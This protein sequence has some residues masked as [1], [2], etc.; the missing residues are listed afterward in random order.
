[1]GVAYHCHLELLKFLVQAGVDKDKQ[2]K[3]STGDK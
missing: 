3:V 1:M 2:S